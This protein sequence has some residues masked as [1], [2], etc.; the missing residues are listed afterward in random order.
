VPINSI[1]PDLVLPLAPVETLG[2]WDSVED[3]LQVVLPQDFKDYIAVFGSGVIGEFITILNPFSSRPT[4]NLIDQSKRQLNA[5]RELRDLGEPQPFELHPA[6]PGLLPVAMT[7]NGDVIHWLTTENSSD[8]TVVVNA[9]RSPDYEHFQYSLTDFIR[10]VIERTIHV[11][12]FPKTI[13]RN[14]ATFRT[15]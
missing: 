2:D 7:D 15:I 5:L 4:L 6:K 10:G 14:R 12:A 3:A 9:A 1:L 8:W 13:F 11:S